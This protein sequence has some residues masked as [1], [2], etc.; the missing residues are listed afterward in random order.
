MWN[1]APAPLAV[2]AN[3]Y[4]EV[5]ERGPHGSF[6]Q[7][8]GNATGYEWSR[9]DVGAIERDVRVCIG[10]GAFGDDERE[11]SSRRFR[12]VVPRTRSAYSRGVDGDDVVYISLAV[13]TTTYP[14]A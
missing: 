11:L 13:R 2:R 5:S 4:L 1:V 6:K 12:H 7:Q 3:P 9:Q 14:V 10:R 8:A